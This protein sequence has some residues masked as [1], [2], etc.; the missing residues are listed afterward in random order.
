M[1]G[2]YLPLFLALV[3]NVTALAQNPGDF[4]SATSGPWHVAATWEEFDG[5]Q[6]NPAAAPPNAA[7]GTTSITAFTVVDVETAVTG[8]E[9][10]VEG[11]A[12]L[13]IQPN[14]G[15]LTVAAGGLVVTEGDGFF[16][17]DG[18]MNVLSGITPAI[19]T[20]QGTITSS[21][22]NLQVDGTYI[23][24]QN[25]GIIPNGSWNDGSLTSITGIT[26]AGPAGLSGQSFYDVTWNCTQSV[27]VILSGAL[28]SVRRHLSILNTGVPAAASLSLTAQAGGSYD[29]LIIGGDLTIAGNAALGFGPNTGGVLYSVSI[30]GNVTVASTKAIAFNVAGAGAQVSISVA[31]NF[32]KNG[33]TGMSL[34]NTASS[35]NNGSGTIDV[36]GNFTWAGGNLTMA[37]GSNGS[38][39]CIG[40][41]NIGGDLTINGG[42]FTETS[43]S[44]N[45][46]G[47]IV[48][49]DAHTHAFTSS[50]AAPFANTINFT[51]P[52]SNRLNIGATTSL[53]GIGGLSLSAGATLG[54]ASPQGISLGSSIGNIRV[55]AA[56]RVYAINSNIVY[57]GSGS[58]NLG[59]EWGPSGKLNGI[60][61]NLEIA[62][63]AGVINNIT[64]STN[65]VGNLTLTSGA[66]DI[67]SGN[68]LT[69]QS[70]FTSAGGT[71]TGHLDSNLIFSGSGTITGNLNFTSG[72]A[73]LNNLTI[74]RA[75]TILLGSDLTINQTGALAFQSSGSLRINGNTLTINGDITQTGVGAIATNN[76]AS[77]LI[78]GGSGTLSSLPLC[79][80]C[81]FTN[82]FNNVTLNRSGG[83][84]YTWNSAANIN[85]TLSLTAGAFTHSSGLIM[86]TGSTFERSAGTTFSGAAPNATTTYNVSYV[87]NVT[88]SGELPTV[89]SN[90]LNNLTVSG[91]VTLDKNI[92]INGNVSITSGTLDATTHNVNMAGA[93]FAINGGSFNINSANTITF[94][95][96]GVT[97]LNGTTIGGSTFGNMTINSGATVDAPNANINITGVWTNNGTFNPNQGTVTFNGGSQ[98]INA[99]GGSFWNL[100][101]SAGTKTLTGN[102]DVNGTLNITAGSSLNAST[103]TINIA[104]TWDNQGAFNPG[105][106]TVV[107]DGATAQGID[108]NGQAFNNLTLANTGVKTLESA[109]EVD[110][111]LTINS[112]STLD[113]S[114][115]NY[116]INVGGAWSNNGTFNPGAG[117][118][119]FDG[120]V[121]QFVGGTTNTQFYDITQTNLSTVTISTTQ[122]LVNA[123]T[124]QAGT[125]NPNGNFVMLSTPSRDARINELTGGATIAATN[126]TIQRYLPNVVGQANFRYI[127]PSVTNAFAVG[128]KDD[129]PITGPFA[130]HSIQSEWSGLPAFN[131]TG[132]SIYIYNEAHTP[133]STVNDR[134]EG[135]PTAAQLLTN[136]PLVNGRGYAA[137]VRQVAPITIE[138]VGRA[139]FGQVDVTVT[140]QAAAFNDGWNLI[141]NPY[142]AP[143]NWDNVTL[144]AG[145]NSQITVL[146]NMNNIGLGA[147]TY[148]YYTQNGVGIPASYDGTIAQGQAFWVRKMTAGPAII[149]FQ[150]DDKV[151]VSAPPFIRD[152]AQNVLRMHV[153]GAGRQDEMV[154]AFA[155]DASDSTDLTHDAFK[156]PNQS[157]TDIF[158]RTFTNVP[159]NSRDMAINTFGALSCSREIPVTFTT[160][161]WVANTAKKGPYA[162][163]FSQLESFGPNVDIRLVD[164]FEGETFVVSPTNTVYNFNVTDD[165]GT[166]GADRFKVYVGYKELDLALA[167]EAK[168]ACEGGEAQIKIKT[169]QP[170]VVYHATLNGTTVSD[171]VVATS[172]DEVIL[173]VPASVLTGSTN[174]LV[175]RAKNGT[176]VEMPLEESASLKVEAFP[177]IS[178]VSEGG[179]CGEG[180][181][182]L[183]A[184][185]APANGTYRWYLTE[186]ATDAIEGE[187]ASSFTTPVLAKTKTYFVSAVSSAGCESGRMAV[188]ATV[189]YLD[190]ATITV[191]GDTFVSN[192]ED[193]N[194]WYLN[195]A[196]IEGATAKTYK[197]TDPGTYKLVVS[198]GECMSEVERVYEVTGDIAGEDLKGYLLYPNPSSGLI[199]VEVQ[200]TNEVAVSIRSTIGTEITKGQLKQDGLRRKGQFDISGHAAGVYLVE[201]KHGEQTVTRKIVKN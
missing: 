134:Y 28:T 15:N 83:A 188:T 1:R 56:T 141:G 70:N 63:P 112:G 200:T 94:S 67:G 199:Y 34:V 20:N 100:I 62:N 187:T 144:P 88:T 126:M 24:A 23:H 44:S 4:R 156:F 168:N 104:D 177:A 54:I 122:S 157:G 163:T 79:T 81:G 123:L 68:T 3:V 146:D 47:E 64:P 8:D 173:N 140:D 74:N 131:A 37:A 17:T 135:F 184:E 162:I 32:T 182:T 171:K 127:A 185:G 114:P 14:G 66:F 111:A 71:I 138:L 72:S 118:V 183:E 160:W 150:E 108:P 58:Q 60:A 9:I 145:L 117:T 176:C 99:N 121:T 136:A 92:R 29:P 6:W 152:A 110:G 76:I 149:S 89:A 40:T 41:L 201:I 31:G 180:S 129:F 25:G 96:A 195:G 155:D 42:T 119:I 109:L 55:S 148:V 101:T 189:S 16:T 19:V 191:E 77:N 178:N 78:I 98:N 84:T 80:S 170:G 105:T 154:I 151:P 167:V 165:A 172:S 69:V 130:D 143:I 158:S 61:V 197:P 181:V 59:D 21:L 107:F 120:S 186:D 139:A 116:T 75:S 86:A 73:I 125:F 124:L 50:I 85:G 194:Q 128:W 142:P 48:F 166:Q 45:G 102:L 38:N 103:F 87:G 159:A 26:T 5:V 46:R 51:I 174:S 164:E 82:E 18:F 113:V 179:K 91:N 12:I 53:S 175:L 196:A 95:R 22:T 33:T 115:T 11:D 35:A 190:D 132:H 10:I 153:A 13:N 97:T 65:L 133:T 30:A 90:A 106:G 52:S 161:D 49:D 43:T 137:L 39:T 193:G 192:S 93:T 147:G 198:N 36:N 2:F 57:N 7:S 169:P 27:A